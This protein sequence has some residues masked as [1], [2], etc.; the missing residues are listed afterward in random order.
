MPILSTNEKIKRLGE[1]KA[2]QRAREINAKEDA[3]VKDQ[4]NKVALATAKQIVES[5]IAQE[6]PCACNDGLDAEQ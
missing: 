1:L 5:Q 2:E 6:C 3:C 4:C